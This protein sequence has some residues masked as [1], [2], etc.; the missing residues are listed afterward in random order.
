MDTDAAGLQPLIE[1]TIVEMDGVP[2]APWV[3]S[4]SGK[5]DVAPHR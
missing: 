4:H 1:D 2:G 3:I 5:Y